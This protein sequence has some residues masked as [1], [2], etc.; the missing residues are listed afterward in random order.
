MIFSKKEIIFPK[1]IK[2][3]E[4]IFQ[5]EVIFSKKK[6]SSVIVK[7]EKIIFRLSSYLRNSQKEKHFKELLIK[8]SK[9][10]EKSPIKKI[11]TIEEVLE[12]GYFIF[13]KERYNL[14]YTKKIRVRLKENTFFI[15]SKTKIENIEKRII[16]ILC[17][18]YYDR[19]KTYLLEKNKETYNYKI[20]GFELKNQSSK[21]G[22]CTYDNKIMLNLKLL[23]ADP[24][25]LDYVIFHEI[26]HIKI[27]NHSKNF[28]NEVSRYSPDYKIYRKVLKDKPPQ[29]FNLE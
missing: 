29:I 28:W 18:K 4:N 5:I 7:G 2:I 16:K 21:W 27:K 9:K 14:E 24:I 8:I 6:S 13:A 15:N 11:I 10:I 12:K 25:I 23:N 19:L 17:E 22:H 26:S 3:G 20:K 1:S